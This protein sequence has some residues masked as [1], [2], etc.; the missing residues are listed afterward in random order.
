MGQPW[1]LFLFIFG[2]FKQTVQFLQ[3]INVKNV[4]SIQYTAP[5]FEPTFFS[6]TKSRRRLDKDKKEGNLVGRREG[7][8]SAKRSTV[9]LNMDKY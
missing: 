1:P 4:T 2:L 5:G 8:N 7:L 3:H 9:I 6:S